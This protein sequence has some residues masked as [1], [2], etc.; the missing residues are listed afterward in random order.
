LGKGAVESAIKARKHRPMFM[1][2]LAVPRDI[3]PEVG[4]LED[5]YLYNIDDLKTIIDE[6]RHCRES[7]ASQAE[8]IIELKAQH[9]IH[10][11]KSL[12]ANHLITQFRA[13]LEQLSNNELAGA[14]RCLQQGADPAQVL[15]Q[16]ATSLTN[17]IAHNPSTQMRQA[18]FDGRLDILA[19]ARQLLNIH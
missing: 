3:E 13:G 9:F 2:D 1:V 16:F 15:Q 10:D 5:V 8:S 6:S 14:L 4:D 17:K 18:A 19:I 7:A 11:L 12:E